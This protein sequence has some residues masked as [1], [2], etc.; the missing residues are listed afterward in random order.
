ME[1]FII[2]HGQSGNNALEDVTKRSKDPL[3]TEIG[4]QQAE[5]VG[6][7]L[8]AGQHLDV[9]EK[10]NGRPFLDRLYCSPMIR[11]LQTARPIGRALGLAPEVW[12]DIHEQGGVFLDHGD[13]RGVVGYPGQTRSQIQEQF[14]EYELPEEVGEEG[15][16]DKGCEEIQGCHGRAIW[17]AAALQERIAEDTRIGLVSHGGFIDSLLKA[18]SH[19]LPGN[20]LHYA[21]HNTAI[22][23]VDFSPEGRTVIRYMNRVDHLSEEL[24]T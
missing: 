20:G 5:C 24:V 2:R 17:V 16:W 14:P 15:W 23:R 18:L 4:E 7:Y 9:A 1:L 21:H 6:P 19:Q 3:L 12:V 22:T 11:T 10:Q 8:G 13:E